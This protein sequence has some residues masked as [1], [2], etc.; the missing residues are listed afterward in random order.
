VSVAVR[1]QLPE[2]FDV[3][4]GLLFSARHD[5]GI[6]LTTR[7]QLAELLGEAGL[8]PGEVFALVD[9]RGPRRHLAETWRHYHDD[10]E[11]FGVPTF[12]LGD[13]DATFVRLMTRPDPA[14]PGASIAVVER[15]LHLVLHQPE[16]NEVKHTRVPL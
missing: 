1:D 12:V 2:S 9:S 3:L 11:V 7:K 6:S 15:L 13:A 16:I 8:E 14:D 4:H 10:L 5:R